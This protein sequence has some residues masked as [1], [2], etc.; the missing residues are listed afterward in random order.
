MIPSDERI[1]HAMHALEQP[2]SDVPDLFERVAKGARRRRR[3]KTGAAVAGAAVVV[4]GI[5]SVPALTGGTHTTHESSPLAQPR[6]T[7]P[8]SDIDPGFTGV[9]PQPSQVVAPTTPAATIPAAT[10]PVIP[11]PTPLPTD[12]KGCPTVDSI[13]PGADA[14]AQATAA[15]LA[16]VPKRYGV[17]TATVTK[18]YPAA[19]KQ[20]FGIVADAICGIALGDNSYVVELN[21]G[22]GGNSASLGSGQ[23]FVA[24]FPGGWQVWFQYH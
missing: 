23:L 11:A 4:A 3:V 6:N 7:L 8:G 16:A 5:A 18:V 1:T 9:A 22:D 10:I 21:L 20:G 24:N 13:A 12:A 17:A 2:A 14:E 19:T 15:A